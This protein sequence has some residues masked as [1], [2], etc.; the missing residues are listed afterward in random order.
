LAPADINWAGG[1][2]VV[3]I[4]VLAGLAGSMGVDLIE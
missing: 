4:H 3:T 1:D 2:G